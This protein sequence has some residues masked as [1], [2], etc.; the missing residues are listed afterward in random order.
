[1]LNIMDS[2]PSTPLYSYMYLALVYI[3]LII[4]LLM[5]LMHLIGQFSI[6]KNDSLPLRLDSHLDHLSV[7][8]VTIIRPLRGL[9]DNLEK[10][11]TSSFTQSFSPIQILFVV[12][13]EKD[14]SIHVAN[15]VSSK[16]PN[17][18][19]SVIIAK[20]S[21]MNPKVSNMIAGFNNAKYDLV[22][23]C[24]SNVITQP[25]FL[26]LAVSQ[27]NAN[28]SKIGAVHQMI[29]ST[30]FNSF[31][32]LLESVFLNTTHARMYLALN[33]INV[34]SCLMGKS[35]VYSISEIKKLG[36]ID[37]VANYIA[38]DNV[39]GQKFWN[40]GKR[41]RLT[42]RLATTSVNNLSLSDY[43]SRRIRWI[44]TRKFNVLSATLFEPFTECLLNG[45]F[46][47]FSLSYLFHPFN[48]YAF[49]FAHVFVWFALDLIFYSRQSHQIPPNYLKDS[50]SFPQ[51]L[52]GWLLRESLALPIWL[53][54]IFGNSVVWRGCT[55]LLN[56]DGTINKFI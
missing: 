24:D 14:P 13:D 47:S 4:W 3:G 35:N 25:D 37:S 30:Q 39:I 6:K 15:S 19:S 27:F 48:P 38:E 44:R 17:I 26:S 21:S 18:D 33:N 5:W 2:L 9:E 12:E 51:F 8:G 54:A 42:P 7:S 32:G 29:W 45:L 10:C 11:L 23:V 31:G 36:G 56:S 22:W 50:F 55:Y 53:V 1:S 40:A 28:P 52:F 34:A 16:F 43:C 41:H 49:F 46:A 20:R